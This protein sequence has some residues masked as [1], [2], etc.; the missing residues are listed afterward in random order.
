MYSEHVVSISGKKGPIENV[1][2]CLERLDLSPF[3][4]KSIL[5]TPNIG[6]S[7]RPGQGYNTNPETLSA[8]IEVFQKIPVAKIAIGESPLVGIDMNEAYE[9]GGI[10]KIAKKHI[11]SGLL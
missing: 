7:A 3:K 9:R 4:N 2:S 6:R 1:K 10:T 11:F 5:L 8:I